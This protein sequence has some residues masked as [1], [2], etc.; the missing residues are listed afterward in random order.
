MKTKNNKFKYH[1]PMLI[2]TY[3]KKTVNQKDYK[4]FAFH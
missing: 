4:V 3:H 1:K 2:V